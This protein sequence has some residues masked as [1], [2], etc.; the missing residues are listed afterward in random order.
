MTG[1]IPVLAA[2]RGAS[3]GESQ[4]ERAGI[5]RKVA[6]ERVTYDVAVV[7]LG[8]V[9]LPTALGFHHAGL[10]VL[11]IDAQPA[12]I[13]A[14]RAGAADLVDDDGARLQ[15]ALVD[16][17][18][19]L[20]DRIA[21]LRQA[22]SV[23]ICVPTPV[24]EHQVPDLSILSAAAAQVVEHA[25]AGQLILLVS[26]TYVGCTED[27]LVR[28]L[29]RR[30]FEVGTDIHVAFSPERI[31][32][33][34]AV[35]TH[36]AVPRVIGGAS[37]A[38]SQRAEAL[39]STAVARIHHVGSIGEAEMSKLLENTF[40][41]VN[42]ALANEVADICTVLGLDVTR[43][44]DAAATKPYGFMAFRPGPGVGGHCI[45]CDPHYLLWQLRSERLDPPV[46]TQAMNA[47][48]AR[49]RRVV[50][51]V[52]FLLGESGTGLRGARVLVVGLAYKPNVADLRESPALEILERLQ[53]EGATVGF[54]DARFEEVRLPGGSRLQ[55]AADPA[56]FQADLVVLHTL[57]DDA[58]LEWIRE[59]DLVLDTT[60]RAS[61]PGLRATL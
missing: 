16:P 50:D 49:P 19:R 29:M 45:P 26:T 2:P 15:R 52:R 41:A 31:D 18:F 30:G 61:V 35:F 9:G 46:I 11:G 59:D 51:R 48:A 42:I 17:A 37:A 44:I 28:P 23:V 3:F 27:F 39:L 55:H 7:G 20:T 47:I 56:S 58:G 4:A 57:H 24:D 5:R 10:T 40:R 33:G 21:E 14:I 60:Y 1:T 36:D 53:D 22:A 12:R 13:A 25:Q 34:N 38:C 43:V 32:P 8:Y 54:H 6:H